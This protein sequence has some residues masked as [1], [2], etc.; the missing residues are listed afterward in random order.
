MQCP[1]L[2][3]L[4]PNYSA[5]IMMSIGWYDFKMFIKTFLFWENQTTTSFWP[6]DVDTRRIKYGQIATLSFA[7]ADSPFPWRLRLYLGLMREEST[8]FVFYASAQN[9]Q[10]SNFIHYTQTPAGCMAGW[11]LD[12]IYFNSRPTWYMRSIVHLF[13]LHPS[14]VRARD[15]RIATRDS[16][17]RLRDDVKRAN[18]GLLLACGALHLKQLSPG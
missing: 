17:A 12:N 15:G 13:V 2:F 6:N 11:L 8:C 1:R 16:A 18:P 7:G 10:N 4:K 14:R 5:L 3:S 9:T